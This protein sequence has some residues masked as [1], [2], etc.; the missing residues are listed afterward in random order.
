VVGL[1][2]YKRKLCFHTQK[3]G[4]TFWRADHGFG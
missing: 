4:L 3:F 1:N 2:A